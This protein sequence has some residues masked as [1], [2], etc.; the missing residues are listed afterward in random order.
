MLGATWVASPQA[1]CGWTDLLFVLG[2][3]R[4]KPPETGDAQWVA[5]PLAACGWTA[6]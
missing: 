3:V 2:V 5:S 6:L 4:I 1:A